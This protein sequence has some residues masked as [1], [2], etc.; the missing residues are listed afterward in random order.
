MAVCSYSFQE[1]LECVRSFHNYPAPGVLIGGFMVDLAYRKLPEESLTDALC[2]TAK[3]LP[4]AIQILTPCTIGNGWLKIIDLGRF[5]LTLYDKHSGEGV[6]VAVDPI[7]LERWPEIR[8]WFFKLKTKKDQDVETL[9]AQIEEA[10]DSYCIARYVKV[11]DEIRKKKHREGFAVCACCGE[12]FPLADGPLC[13]GC[14][15]AP[16]FEMHTGTVDPASLMDGPN[17]I[18][19]RSRRS[20]GVISLRSRAAVKK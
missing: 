8:H 1:Y 13:L 19:A 16:L 9:M 20:P 2:E 3:C 4:D 12:A 5:A 11:A 17:H 10:E 7:A 18:G 6:R 14:Q 15:D